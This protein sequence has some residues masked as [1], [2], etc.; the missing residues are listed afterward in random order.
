MSKP[1]KVILS[2]V[3]LAILLP[4]VAAIIAIQIIDTDDIKRIAANQVAAH[5]G[6]ELTIE[7]AVDL[8]LFPWLSLNLGRTKLSNAPGFGTTPMIEVEQIS[9]SLK[10][11]PL[12]SG[13]IELDTIT[14]AGLKID[15]QINADGR[16][17][18]DDLSGKTTAKKE[19][20][21]TTGSESSADKN[22]GKTALAAF[23]LGG[24]EITNAQIHWRDQTSQTDI[25]VTDFNLESGAI[26][27]GKAV[28]I[29][30]SAAVAMAEPSMTTQLNSRAS[31]QISKDFQRITLDDFS[32]A[33]TANGDSLP[34]GKISARLSAAISADLATDNLTITSLL[35]KTLGLEVGGDLTVTKFSQ[36]PA[37]TAQLQLSPFNGQSLLAELALPPAETADADAL[38]TISA[39]LALSA[40]ENQI[41]LSSVALQLDQT[42]INGNARV[43]SFDQPVISFKLNL[44]GIDLDRYLPPPATGPATTAAASNGSGDEPL[45]L[46]ESLAGLA[47]L[48]LNGSLTIGEL[49]VSNIKSSELSLTVKAS[50]GHLI[51]DPMSAKLYDGSLSGSIDLNG[52][53]RP[54]VLSLVQKLSGVEIGPLAKDAAG[55]DRLTGTATISATLATQGNLQEELIRNLNGNLGFD[56]ANGTLQGI[57][58]DRSTCLARQKLNVLSGKNQDPEPCPADEST[59]FTVFQAAAKVTHGVLQNNDLF[60]EQQRSDA[61][62]FLHIKGSGKVDLNTESLDYRINAGRVEK[63]ADGS[64]QPRGTAI[65]VRI[66]GSLSNPSVLPDVS[67]LV[68]T[69]AK[70]KLQ[71]K[72]AP[73]LAPSDQDSPTDQLKKQLLRGLFN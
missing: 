15:L 12:F 13:N 49:T 69:E 28:E 19:A 50:K 52:A 16:S 22:P 33:V 36:A 44:D 40:D 42:Q 60:I 10:L 29:S 57:N 47:A 43:V 45:N 32:L 24:I 4:I 66:S 67:D 46:G 9:V 38:K 58:V 31:L 41:N 39:K 8:S 59:R 65:P 71:E 37:V 17:N 20:S 53:R 70:N 62:K 30:L 26:A 6:R 73:Q 72:F 35:L 11:L 2:L 21:T 23:T 14:L 7:G 51:L 25:T 68:K 64:Y 54:P 18:F 5:S 61:R 34:G 27:P 48:N 56:I 1:I 3:V 63:L 55:I